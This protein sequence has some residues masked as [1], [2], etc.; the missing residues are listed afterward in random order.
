[1]RARMS[2]EAGV[3]DMV[4]VSD[5]RMSGI[6]F[7]TVVLPWAPESPVGGPLAL[8]REGDMIELN[9][10]E[11]RIDLLVGGSELERRRTEFVPPLLPERGWQRL[12]VHHVTPAHM[13]ADL[14]F[15]DAPPPATSKPD[16][17][18]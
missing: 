2:A 4:R 5:A 11:R 16:T 13:G 3:R 9:V 12:F 15:L 14:D 18:P 7:G 8:V 17:E 1:M 6:A 10:P